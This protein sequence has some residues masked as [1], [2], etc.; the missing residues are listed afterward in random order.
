MT[1]APRVA[2]PPVALSND[3]SDCSRVLMGRCCQ[4]V[5]LWHRRGHCRSRPCLQSTEVSLQLTESRQCGIDRPNSAGARI[6]CTARLNG[7]AALICRP[8][9]GRMRDTTACKD[10]LCRLI[11]S[12]L[13][14]CGVNATG[15]G[16]GTTVM[17]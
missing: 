3:E 9:T 14:T 17:A 16:D 10:R 15:N 4:S 1:L 7:G 13:W 2:R 6:S 12:V 5:R 8:A 11:Q